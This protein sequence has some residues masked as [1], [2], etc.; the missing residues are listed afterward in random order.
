MLPNKSSFHR[1][2]LLI[3]FAFLLSGCAGV[4]GQGQYQLAQN[5]QPD[6]SPTSQVGQTFTS[7]NAGLSGLQIYMAP[8]ASDPP[9]GNIVLHL[10]ENA[11][12][13][14]ILYAILAAP[15]IDH[16]GYYRFDFMAQTDSYQKNYYLLLEMQG[17]G[18]I[19]VGTASGDTY[20]D[21]ALYLNGIPQDAQL[22]FQQVYAPAG[23][24][25]GMAQQGLD[26]LWK[27]LLACLVFVIP[28]WALLSGLWAGWPGLD[29]MEKLGL[30]AGVSLGAIPVVFLFTDLVG[31]HL[32]PLYAWLPAG[33]GL[34]YLAWKNRSLLHMGARL[35]AFKKVDWASAS[36]L[37]AALFVV[38]VRLWVVRG[39]DFPLFGDAYQ[40]TMITQLM[41]DQNG[42]FRSWAP[43]VPYTSLTVQYGFPAAAAVF[44]WV[45]GLGAAASTV[46]VG[47]V[48]NALAVLALYPL[49]L[50][51]SQGRRWAGIVT[52][53]LGGLF[54]PM[55]MMYVN[56]GRFAQLGGQVIL[57][58]AIWLTWDA[59][60]GQR[61]DLKKMG[62]VG[63][64]LAGMLLTYYRMLFYFGTFFIAWFLLWALPEW[65]LNF[66]KW[67][68]FLLSVA[69]IVAV[70]LALLLPWLV[71][72]K[73][74]T[75]A[76]GIENGLTAA[77]SPL[78]GILLD[79]ASWKE[80]GNYVTP[81]ILGLAALAAVWGLVRRNW[82]VAGIALWAGLLA[83]V[84]AGQ[85]IHLPGANMMQSFAVLIFLYAP[86]SLLV[87]W[88][89]G[90]AAEWLGRHLGRTGAALLTLL[91][92]GCS[93]WG[94]YG[95]R[96][97]A[98]P[99][100]F[101][102]VTRPDVRAAEWIR[103]NTDPGATFLVEGFRIY[104]GRS[105]VGSDAG[106]WLPLLANRKNSMPPQYALLNEAPRPADYSQKVVNL[107]AALEKNP[108]T[109]PIAL[110]ALC[111]MG[112]THV[113]IGQEQGLIGINAVQLFNREQFLNND[114]FTE[115]Y[116]QDRVSIFSLNSQACQKALHE[117]LP[118]P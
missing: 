1:T 97:M 32:G 68:T 29:W 53:L 26:W 118:K 66:K 95:F 20:L 63:L 49:A 98:N 52:I 54:I 76:T 102:L 85:L 11:Q 115:I 86:A 82:M 103:Q 81:V 34:V 51:L 56:W 28:G 36:L 108:P 57:P 100:G 10:K 79:Y 101:G 25:L 2:F 111:Q 23:L 91:V 30:A 46:W 35:P 8:E 69:A 65:R 93:A 78:Q 72:V 55:P 6:I 64:T 59:L 80:V 106:W 105:A 67:R 21:G 37:I 17:S 24:A 42:L 83:A 31:L 12:A 19:R 45:S 70:S 39:I 88:L 38:G 71:R 109:T 27:L 84:R 77:A 90:E 116:H 15:S 13:E 40:H 33:V 3:I 92:I 96:N 112:I 74:S 94:A 75:L 107:V 110:A 22:T 99:A 61:L 14:D 104:D 5:F 114:Q 87:G 4:V 58:A 16:P 50:R 43:Y 41:L 73:G 44:A 7:R 47:Q 18:S 89:L 117:D 60:A 62:L 9:S 113:Y 48:Q